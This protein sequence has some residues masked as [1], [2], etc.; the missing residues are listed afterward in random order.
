MKAHLSFRIEF[1]E[2]KNLGGGGKGT[3][4]TGY[5]AALTCDH[6]HLNHCQCIKMIILWPNF[7]VKSKVYH[8]RHEKFVLRPKMGIF[9]V[10]NFV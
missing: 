6:D 5:G 2:R 7:V 10:I 3:R 4:G 9:A 8:F 1:P